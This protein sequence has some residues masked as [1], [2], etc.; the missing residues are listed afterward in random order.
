DAILWMQN[1]TKNNK[2]FTFIN[3]NTDLQE[4]WG[5]KPNGKAKIKIKELKG[6]YELTLGD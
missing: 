5:L 3:I 2:D 1:E 4:N 6:G